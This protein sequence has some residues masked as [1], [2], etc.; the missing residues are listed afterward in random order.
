MYVNRKEGDRE[1]DESSALTDKDLAYCQE[2]QS[3]NIGGPHDAMPGPI[4]SQSDQ[5]RPTGRNCVICGMRTRAICNN[6]FCQN[7]IIKHK[8]KE[9]RGTPICNMTKPRQHLS[10]YGLEENQLTCLELHRIA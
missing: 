6:R 4:M 10:K 2:V 1:S 8:S 7:R 5:A 9:Q 3:I